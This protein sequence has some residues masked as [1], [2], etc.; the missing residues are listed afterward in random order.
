MVGKLV[1]IVEHIFPRGIILM[2]ASGVGYKIF[3][4]SRSVFNVGDKYS[5]RNS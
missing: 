5:C 3:I 4:T 2:T 1:G